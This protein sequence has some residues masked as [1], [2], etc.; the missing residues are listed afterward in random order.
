MEQMG[1]S[2]FVNKTCGHHVHFD[3]EDLQAEDIRKL[4]ASFFIHE[5]AFDL[6]MPP[7]R[8]ANQNERFLRSHRAA[9]G[10]DDATASTPICHQRHL[11]LEARAALSLPPLL[12]PRARARR[13]PAPG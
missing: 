3:A 5:E 6:L 9:M 1:H 10:C 8:Q 2:V 11:D 4:A 7:S 13:A 12:A